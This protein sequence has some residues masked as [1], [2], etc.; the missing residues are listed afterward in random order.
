M[1]YLHEF[2]LNDKDILGYWFVMQS[3]LYDHYKIRNVCLEVVC[4]HITM[5]CEIDVTH[6]IYPSINRQAIIV[7]LPP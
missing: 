3:Q 1:N 5:P 4:C 2:V 6:F 7:I